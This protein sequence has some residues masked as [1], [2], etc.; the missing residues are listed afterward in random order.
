MSGESI[1][2]DS[3]KD[4]NEAY[5]EEEI[6]SLVTSNDNLVRSRFNINNNEEINFEKKFHSGDEEVGENNIN[7]LEKNSDLVENTEEEK[8]ELS[9]APRLNMIA[10]I[11]K[12]WEERKYLKWKNSFL[13]KKSRDFLKKKKFV[14][15]FE[16]SNIF[17]TIHSDHRY[18][19]VL[20]E[21]ETVKNSLESSKKDLVQVSEESK[22]LYDSQRAE[23][24]KSFEEFRVLFF[25]T[26]VEAF[27]KK[28]NKFKLAHVN[29]KIG[30]LLAKMQSR[31]E[32]LRDTRVVFFNLNIILKKLNDELSR[33]NIL[34]EGYTVS[35]YENLSMIKDSH[36]EI[37]NKREKKIENHHNKCVAIID[38]LSKVKEQ[39]LSLD[40]DILIYKNK[41]GELEEIKNK[42]QVEFNKLRRQKDAKRKKISSL[43]R[44]LFSITPELIKEMSSRGAEYVKL[45]SRIQSMKESDDSFI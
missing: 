4:L 35:E 33:I 7:F 5:N 41:L 10:Q 43:Q 36:V 29:K 1:K 40:N 27:K 26:G 13:H 38:M 31:M 25:E 22:K 23:F 3:S 30:R 17:S 2:A 15:Y 16:K 44:K 32:N 45:R 6:K 42:L 12:I 21:F 20:N 28:D 14:N 11:K 37:F 34:G 39:L 18:E 8:I 9:N 19:A 24:E